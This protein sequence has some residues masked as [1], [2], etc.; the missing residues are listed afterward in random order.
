MALRTLPLSPLP[1]GICCVGRLIGAQL[2]A[3]DEHAGDPDVVEDGEDGADEDRERSSRGR[4]R[5]ICPSCVI[6]PAPKVGP[7]TV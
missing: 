7:V 2:T 1:S 6:A 4:G 5:R 3:H